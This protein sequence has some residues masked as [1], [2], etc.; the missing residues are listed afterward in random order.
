M[1]NVTAKPGT[2][3]ALLEGL[4]KFAN[5]YVKNEEKE[6]LTYCVCKS[7]DDDVTITV[8]ERYTGKPA[9]EAHMGSDGF[10]SLTADVGQH[11]ADMKTGGYKYV[12]GHLEK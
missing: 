5:T 8:F 4:V 3:D 7:L 11:I 1:A 12:L 2:R 10:K 9:Y 6:T